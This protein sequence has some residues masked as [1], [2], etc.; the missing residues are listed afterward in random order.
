MLL[1]VEIDAR[2]EVLESLKEIP[3]VKEAHRLYGVYDFI[4]R[5]EAETVQDL[6]DLINR[7]RGIEK[8]RSTM[9]LICL[10]EGDVQVGIGK[11]A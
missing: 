3:E 5:V 7:I 9:P 10:K 4:I 6:K 8:I 1:T 11:R 2:R